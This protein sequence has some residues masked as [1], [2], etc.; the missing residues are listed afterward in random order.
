MNASVAPSVEPRTAP[1][2]V[3]A[4]SLPAPLHAAAL[5]IFG[6]SPNTSA[7]K[8]TAA[9]FFKAIGL[10][11]GGLLFSSPPRLVLFEVAGALPASHI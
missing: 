7:A 11:P 3:Q 2:S 8:T 10:C 6:T 5:A 1:R 9:A 4:T